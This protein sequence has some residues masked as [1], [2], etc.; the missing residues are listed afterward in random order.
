MNWFE[1]RLKL[2]D[3]WMCRLNKTDMCMVRLKLSAKRM[4][5]NAGTGGIETAGKVHEMSE[6][7]W[8]FVM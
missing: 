5:N 1:G 7:T 2:V 6:D 8:D 4:I 3:D